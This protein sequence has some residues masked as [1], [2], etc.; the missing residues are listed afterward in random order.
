[1]PH[2]NTAFHQLLKPV[3]RH[4]F[5]RLAARHHVGQKLRSARRWDQFVAMGLG[6]M[7]DRQSLR[8]IEAN[9]EAQ[10]DKLYHLGA[11]VIAKTTLARLNEQQP[12]ALY[13]AV[14]YQLLSRHSQSPGKHK[15][16]F[17]NPLYSL[18]ASA[19]DLSSPVFPWARHR[20]DTANVK[21]SIGLNHAT[22]IPEYVAV[23]DGH[24]NDM[25]QGRRFKFPKG[26]IVAFDKGYIDYE[27]F[28]NL[29]KQGVFFVTRLRAG[30]VYKVRERREVIAHSGVRSDQVIELTSAHAKKRGAPLLR[31]VGY[32]DRDSGKFYEFLTNNVEL[33]ARTIA[34]IYKDRWQVELFFKAIKS[35]LKINKF[36]GHSRNAVLTQLWIALI[37]YLLIAIARHSAQQGWTVARM[38]KVLQLNIFSRKT[39]KQLLSPDKSRHKK[40]DPQMRIAL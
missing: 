19:I 1:M 31:R 23:G 4:E 33:S 38:M 21:L 9:L 30:T 29:T 8:D 35:C 20:E 32:Q 11:K 10:S 22:D 17:K 28:G 13:Q 24:E 7:S 40:S 27:W 14:F 18:D 39:L 25:V 12:A 37:M 16:R 36:V 2:H 5:E 26:S 34:A 6:Q 3:S 15:F